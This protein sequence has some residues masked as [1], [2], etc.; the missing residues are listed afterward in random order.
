M[1]Y[2]DVIVN[3]L[4]NLWR[5]KLR[6]ILTVSG[7]VIAI[8]AFVTMLSFGIGMQRNVSEQFEKL[9]LLSTMYVYPPRAEGVTDSIKIDAVLNED[10]IRQ[11]AMIPGV[12]LAYPL[13]EF[14]VTVSFGDSTIKS[15][16]RALPVAAASTRLFSDL[17]A[18]TVFS[19]DSTRQV[20][21]SSRFVDMAGV[22]QPDSALG[23]QLVIS[24][25][26]TSI[27]SAL[28]YAVDGLGE[29]IWTRVSSVWRDSLVSG[30][31]LAELAKDAA[32][33]SM[34]RFKDGM[35]RTG[36]IDSAFVYA[37]AGLRE[38]LQSRMAGAWRDTVGIREFA[39]DIAR[40]VASRGMSQFI[41]GLLNA[42]RTLTDTLTVCG[43][44][45]SDRGGGPR[46]PSI[47][48]P[49]A[50]ATRLNSGDISDDPT[51]MMA[52]LRSGE[53]LGQSELYGGREYPRVTL[54]LDPQ[55]AYEPIRDSIKSLGFRTF[56]FV[57]EFNE[58]RK[59]FRYFNL[60]LS[61]VGII[62]LITASLG[63]VNTMV[64]SILERKRE[65][66]VLKSLGA[67]D[68]DI[69][70]MFLIESGLIGTIGA[71][72]GIVFGWIITR[73]ATAIAHSFMAKEGVPLFDLFAFPLWLIAGAVGF[74]L[75]VSLGAGLYPASRAAR[76]DPVQALRQD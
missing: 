58:M 25:E 63:I 18:G 76:V 74:G 14:D 3:A 72:V 16:A 26:V 30:D 60:G 70:R 20:L 31:T 7:I 71:S 15:Q 27:D 2:R 24:S 43:V 6:S 10:A 47:I 65:I 48:I 12:N 13:D 67:D 36:R 1:S 61:M 29:L 9:G 21:V 33:R 35:R 11:F 49:A 23:M 41:N 66:G 22:K 51:T 46:F 75:L 64:M 28:A 45:E 54:D 40:D 59:F 42:R 55:V 73:I 19:G 17:E 34:S 37:T 8:A 62:A 53:L 50:T 38:L 5:M 56:S 52:S 44:I 57:E 69:R 4:G 68:S 39:I 32:G